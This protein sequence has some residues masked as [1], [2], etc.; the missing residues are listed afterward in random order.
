M[1]TGIDL[2]EEQFNVTSGSQ[3]NLSQNEV[4][5]EGWAINCRINAEDPRRGFTPSPGTVI[6]YRPPAGPG[7]RVDSALYS[8]HMIPEYYDSMVAKLAA[9]GRDRDEAIRR[10]RVAL[11]EIEIVGVPTTVPLHRTLMR[12]DRFIRGEF[13]TTYLDNALSRM[14]VDLSRLEKFAAAAAVAAKLSAPPTIKDEPSDKMISRWR[15]SARTQ[16]IH[17]NREAGW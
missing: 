4:H 7:I 15:T 17:H 2:I 3:L 11:D 16:L 9:W 13:D 10:M 8:G 12:D 5:V 14:N 6:H 1:T